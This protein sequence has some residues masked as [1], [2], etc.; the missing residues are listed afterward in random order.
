MFR[1]RCA[2]LALAILVAVSLPDAALAVSANGIQDPAGPVENPASPLVGRLL[3]RAGR[4]LAGVSV[5]LLDARGRTLGSRVTDPAG[6]FDFGSITPG[7]YALRAGAPPDGGDAERRAPNAPEFTEH[8]FAH[9][10]AGTDLVLVAGEGRL[11]PLDALDVRV[12]RSSTAAAEDAA[13]TAATLSRRDLALIPGVAE[14]DV[15]RAVELLP[16]VVSTSDF[17]AAFHVRGGGADQNLILLDGFPIFNPF[18]LGG[19]F[20]VFNPDMVAG[21]ELFTGGLPARYAGRVSSVLEVSSDAGEG[22]HRA[23]GGVSLLA[24]RASFGGT[25]LPVGRALGMDGIGGRIAVRRSYL[26]VV[27]RPFVEVPYSLLDVHAHAEAWKGGRDRVWLTGYTGGDDLD[28]ARLDADDVP[29]RLR[30]RWGNDVLGLGWER[31]LSGGGAVTGRLGVS[32]FDTDLTL[33]DFDDTSLDSNIVQRLARLDASFGDGAIAWEAGASF[34]HYDYRN[35]AAAG[36]TT[37]REAA[38][39]GSQLGAYLEGSWR[40]GAWH[41]QPGMRMDAWFAEGADAELVLQPRVSLRRE[42][43]ERTAVKASVG[44]LAQFLHSVRDEELPIGIDIWVLS[45]LR[46]PTLLSNQAQ[47]GVEREVGSAWFVSAEAYARDFEGVITNNFSEDPNDALDDLLGGDGDAWGADLFVERRAGRVRGWASAS[48]LRAERTF[49]NDLEPQPAADVSYPPIY[50]RRFDLDV[51]LTTPLWGAWEG[52][53]RWNFGTGL[54]FTRPLGTYAAFDYR[55]VDGTIYRESESDDAGEAEEDPFATAVA[56]G[57][58]NAERLP[59]VHRLDLSLRRPFRRSWG[60][61][62][63]RI[64]L[65]NAYNR[66]NPLL[67]FYRYDR[68]PPVR[69]GIAMFPLLPSVGLDVR[70]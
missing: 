33:P 19:L 41:V 6:D 44:R 46:A 58:R 51:V 42:L 20:G 38:A 24:G 63:L 53:L 15:V 55:G 30:W 23:V 39:A 16:G 22:L 68:D 66:K 70:F 45:G 64:D 36:G 67:Y 13:L 14:A 8:R 69:E 49:P 3:D 54:P 61:G 50:D 65:I 9:G 52:G 62:T 11:V 25:S 12:N 1:P 37:F 29:L 60:E 31:R 59:V 21:A 7:T 17:T 48:L 26:D 34:D 2:R 35:R 5:A 57:P 56:L 10:G 43:D 4:P 40:P 28:L 32:R 18:H 27:L 47:V